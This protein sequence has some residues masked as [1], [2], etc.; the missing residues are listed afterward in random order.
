MVDDEKKLAPRLKIDRRILTAEL[1]GGL[2][3]QGV[4]PVGPVDPGS[5]LGVF[6]GV[7]VGEILGLVVGNTLGKAD[8]SFVG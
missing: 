5:S 2:V 6:V 3:G 8:G 7:A 4:D 1:Q